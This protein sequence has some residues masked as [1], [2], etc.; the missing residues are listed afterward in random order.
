MGSFRNNIGPSRYT[1]LASITVPTPT[2]RAC[3]GTFDRSLLKNLALAMIVSCAKVF[4]R[5]LPR[6]QKLR[7]F[8]SRTNNA[9][10]KGAINISAKKK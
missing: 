10:K 9:V 5:V 3:L 2:V 8:P 7:S 4:K 6:K 1:S